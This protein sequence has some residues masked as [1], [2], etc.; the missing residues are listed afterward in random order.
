MDEYIKVMPFGNVTSLLKNIFP[1]EILIFVLI[2]CLYRHKKNGAKEQV[3]KLYSK[4]A[5]VRTKEY[6]GR[7]N[8]INIY[9]YKD[10]VVS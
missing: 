3:D 5:F 10:Y 2:G 6:V 7:Q 9:Y 1:V 4:K 8:K